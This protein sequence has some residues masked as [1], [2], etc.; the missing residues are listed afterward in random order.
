MAMSLLAVRT[1]S[2][3]EV[4]EPFTVITA[5]PTLILK[6]LRSSSRGPSRSTRSWVWVTDTFITMLPE[7]AVM[8]PLCSIVTYAFESKSKR[9]PEYPPSSSRASVNAFGPVPNSASESSVTISIDEASRAP[10]TVIPLPLSFRFTE[11]SFRPSAA[12]E[13]S[14]PVIVRFVRNTSMPPQSA[15]RASPSFAEYT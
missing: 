7:E 15:F 12:T 3:A 9:L 2:P 8:D 10:F 1:I 13:Y 5:L 6:K 14:S 11:G 4:M